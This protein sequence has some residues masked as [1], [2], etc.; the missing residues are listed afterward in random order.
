MSRL[1][2]KVKDGGPKS[3]VDA[4]FLCE[5]KN[6]F[7]VALLR[8]NVGGRGVY[9]THAFNAYTWFLCGE[10]VEEDISGDTHKYKASLKPKFTPRSKNH[11][12]KAAKPSW[13][14]TIRGPWVDR[15]EEFDPDKSKRT[16]MTH[17]RNEVEE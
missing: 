9:H 16:V 7:S 15:W 1:V 5:F 11:R 8:F 3:S 10:M 6:L 13:C 4:Y 12:V 17:G 14:F 2:E